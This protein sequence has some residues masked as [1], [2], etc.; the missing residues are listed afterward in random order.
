MWCSMLCGVICGQISRLSS[1]WQLLANQ[2]S[3]S[4]STFQMKLCSLQS[5][6]DT[7]SG[8]LPLQSITVPHVLPLAE[9]L[10]ADTG[11]LGCYTLNAALAHMDLARLVAA[12]SKLYSSTALAMMASRDRV[13]P[14]LMD[15]ISTM[16]H[17]RLLWGARGIAV[18][19][20]DRLVKFAQVLTALSD[21]VEPQES[22]LWPGRF[23]T[24]SMVKFRTSFS[25]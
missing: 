21:K 18:Q 15:M 4:S 6:L 20:H 2:F 24:L 12:E 14:A 17:M 19:R 10:E 23:S 11:A 5:N 1:A 8:T 25:S 16:T 7:S 3:T 22:S 9:L 13:D